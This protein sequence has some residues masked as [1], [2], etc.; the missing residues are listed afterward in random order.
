MAKARE[1]SSHFLTGK[2]VTG[3]GVRAP[4][5]KNDSTESRNVSIYVPKRWVLLWNAFVDFS[6]RRRGLA[7]SSVIIE[8]VLFYVHH[9]SE[10]QQLAFKASLQRVTEE[11]A[12]ECGDLTEL[13]DQILRPG[14][15]VP[16]ILS[17]R[18]EAALHRRQVLYKEALSWLG[19][20]HWEKFRTEFPD[21][22]PDAPTTISN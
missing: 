5:S 20:E 22:D 13:A 19:N 16:Q 11:A 17:G 21:L 9:L 10:E 8:A 6:C 18:S 3:K 2:I 12:A 14:E 1:G 15:T 7:L 4:W